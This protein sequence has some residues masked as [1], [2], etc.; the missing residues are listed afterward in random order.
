MEN[1]IGMSQ[2]ARQIRPSQH[3]YPPSR[4]YLGLIIVG[5]IVLLVGGIIF[6]SYGFLDPETDEL[7]ND[8][9]N[10]LI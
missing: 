3:S 6:A 4:G 5:I 1:E 2:P 10:E 8:D 9:G 7:T